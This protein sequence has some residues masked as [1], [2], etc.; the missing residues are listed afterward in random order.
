[1]KTVRSA[2]IVETVAVQ[3]ENDDSMY[4]RSE[5]GNW[6]VIMGESVEC[7]YQSDDL[8]EAFRRHIEGLQEQPD[9]ETPQRRRLLRVGRGERAA[10]LR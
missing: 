10:P 7:I 9:D 8:E 1:M 5:S 3:F 6:S 2:E 4:F